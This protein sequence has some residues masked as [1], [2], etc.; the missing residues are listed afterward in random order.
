MQYLFD[1]TITIRTY[2]IVKGTSEVDARHNL[3]QGR[4]W[5]S[6]EISKICTECKLLEVAK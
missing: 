4:I 2:R 3:I 1:E 5:H 6:T